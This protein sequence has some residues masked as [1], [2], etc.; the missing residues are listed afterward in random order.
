ML[1]RRV[2]TS[3]LKKSSLRKRNLSN[4]LLMRAVYLHYHHYHHSAGQHQAQ[5]QPAAAYLHYHHLKRVSSN[6]S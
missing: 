2:V 6:A 5:H 3:N 1:V 4:H